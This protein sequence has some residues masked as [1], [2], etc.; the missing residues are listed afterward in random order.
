MSNYTD[1]SQFP[2]HQSGPQQPWGAGQ[3]QFPFPGA[4]SAPPSG[5]TSRAPKDKRGLLAT[6]L[7]IG[8]LVLVAGGAG[9]YV[10]LRPAAEGTI[11]ADESQS[12]SEGA[13]DAPA[14]CDLSVESLGATIP[15]P[16]ADW[17]PV[18]FESGDGY[19]SVGSS[20]CHVQHETSMSYIETGTLD[21]ENYYDP[22]RLGE[23]SAYVAT[24]WA[25]SERVAGADVQGKEVGTPEVGELD[26]N[27]H[28]A[29][30]TELRVT[31]EPAAG[32]TN[33]YEDVS[34]LVVD[35]D[36]ST[37]LVV[38]VSIPQE[39]EGLYDEASQAILATTFTE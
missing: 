15:S 1:N 10:F 13:T 3:G 23:T 27:G 26:F 37:A 22:S 4:Q 18:A 9:A 16:S 20:G 30:L 12:P 6:F 39:G 7:V 17:G 32:T 38:L 8:I 25:E 31:W 24:W 36:G 14:T 28:A 19:A 5:P 35:I 2:Q 11:T 33:S 29:G 21:P 34:V